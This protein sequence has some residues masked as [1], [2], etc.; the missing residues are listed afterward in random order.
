MVQVY[1]D[2]LPSVKAELTYV[3]PNNPGEKMYFYINP[4]HVPAGLTTTN[5]SNQPFEY[6]IQ[7]IRGVEDRFG[8]S[9]SG[10]EVVRTPES[11][12]KLGDG[13]E[14]REEWKDDA[15][16]QDVYYR[17]VE[18]L[19][20]ERLGAHRVHIFDHTIRRQDNSGTIPDTPSTRQP[21][22]RVHVDQTPASAV[23]RVHRHLGADAEEL[24]TRRF[25]LINVW[26]PLRGPV[27]DAP[28]AVAD[29]RSVDAHK[30]LQPQELRRGP[31]EPSG[32]TF[33]VLHNPN[34][35]WYYL[36]NMRPDEAL[37]LKCHDSDHSDGKAT[38]T[39]HTAFYD[40]RHAGKVPAR[41]SIEI[42]TLVFF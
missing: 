5:T 40:P 25:A 26:R 14:S 36:S 28:L 7:D 15:W 10:F 4:D 17:E 16:V 11:V 22:Q 24:L 3:L 19:L 30:D 39:P 18:Q 35:Q 12:A 38:F 6:A 31:E 27:L 32:E 42:R 34:H 20:I 23:A 29:F 13:T 2:S 41:E 9:I 1:Q 37:L 8:L 33:A 21:V